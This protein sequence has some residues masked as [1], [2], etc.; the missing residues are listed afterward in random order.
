MGHCQWRWVT[1]QSTS[2]LS[3]LT[4]MHN[5]LS[6]LPL[7]PPCV[8]LYVRRVRLYDCATAQ[9]YKQILV[10]HVQQC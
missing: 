5:H 3:A 4:V 7:I 10:L 9:F 8:T 6:G 2:I 1:G